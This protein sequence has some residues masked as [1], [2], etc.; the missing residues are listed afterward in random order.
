MAIIFLLLS[1]PPLSISPSIPLR[2]CLPRPNTSHR[3]LLRVLSFSAPASASFS[4]SFS[5]SF[6]GSASGSGSASAPGSASASF[7]SSWASCARASPTAFAT[8]WIHC[9]YEAV[10]VVALPALTPQYVVTLPVLPQ[11]V[12]TFSFFHRLRCR[13][14]RPGLPSP[15][16]PP[17]TLPVPPPV[18]PPTPP[19]VLPPLP[20]VLPPTPPTL[21][22]TPPMSRT[23]S[24]TS[25]LPCALCLLCIL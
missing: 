22:P 3:C 16:P 19:P 6:S 8:S 7:A 20:S 5:T 12:L 14:C 10:H 17:P 2:R 11:L 24:C 18:P 15:A 9:L 4:A 1:L 25:S 13:L 21:P 23:F